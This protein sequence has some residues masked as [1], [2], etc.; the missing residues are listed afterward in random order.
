M[1]KRL[2]FFSTD[3]KR[4]SP[5]LSFGKTHVDA[6]DEGRNCIVEE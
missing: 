2:C 3:D 5:S 4:Q 1:N 6:N